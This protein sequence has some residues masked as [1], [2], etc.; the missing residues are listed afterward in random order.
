MYS[1]SLRHEA[2]LA[3][4]RADRET[5]GLKSKIAALES[6]HT[7]LRGALSNLLHAIDN[8]QEHPSDDPMPAA[9]K[10]AE[11]VLFATRTN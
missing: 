8:P 2:N 6:E 11:D 10:L 5:H 3:R 7:A 9:R 4:N 1:A